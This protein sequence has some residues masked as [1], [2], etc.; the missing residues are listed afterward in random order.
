MQEQCTPHPFIQTC[1]FCNKTFRVRPYEAK[2]G[3][4]YCSRTC[5]K[6]EVPDTGMKKCRKCLQILPFSAFGKQN[7]TRRAICKECARRDHRERYY[8]DH[9]ASKAYYRAQHAINRDRQN[10]ASRRWKE[11]NRSHVEQYQREYN[12]THRDIKNERSRR[13]R[14]AMPREQYL[15]MHRR[16]YRARVISGSLAN[17]QRQNRERISE[18]GRRWR[19]RHPERHAE[20]QRRR[21][22][23]KRMG[24]RL[25]PADY[26]RILERDGL[27]CYLCDTALSRRDVHFDHVIPL[28]KGGAH[29]ESNI[30][31]SCRSCNLRKSA[32]LWTDMV[33]VY[34]EMAK[35]VRSHI[36]QFLI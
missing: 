36:E 5:S 30:R 3:R 33:D 29:H 34:P 1:P 15:E 27:T 31:V 17:W 4:V 18:I 35:R 22:A 9:E 21:S 7:K 10:A 23:A 20:R 24:Q 28:S 11:R 8:A 25:R 2:K 6:W 32:R 13:A 16:W 14:A 12:R 26:S 19:E